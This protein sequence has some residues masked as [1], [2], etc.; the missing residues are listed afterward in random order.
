MNPAAAAAAWLLYF[1]L[2]LKDYRLQKFTEGTV[3]LIMRRTD[4]A[5]REFGKVVVIYQRT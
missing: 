1:Q 5:N 4:L 2:N 3:Y